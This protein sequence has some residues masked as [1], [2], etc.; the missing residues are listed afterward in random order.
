[1]AR[2]HMRDSGPGRSVEARSW[3]IPAWPSGCGIEV[4]I[5][6]ILPR[7]RRVRLT[8]GDAGDAAP[9]TDLSNTTWP[10]V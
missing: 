2:G 8:G 7:L 4:L 5:G 6:K 10:A 9:I 3:S 1:M